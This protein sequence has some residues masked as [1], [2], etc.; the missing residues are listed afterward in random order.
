MMRKAFLVLIIV[1]NA[2]SAMAQQPSAQNQADRLHRIDVEL[3][4]L[5]PVI[6]GFPPNIE[7]EDQQSK[8]EE[9]YRQLVAQINTALVES[10]NDL[11]LLYRRGKLYS[12]GHNIDEPNAWKNAERDL[13]ELIKRKPYD[14][15]AFLEL[16]HLYVNT[17]PDFAPKAEALFLQAQKVHGQEP[18]GEAHR[19]L[20]F[21][22]YYQGKMQKALGEADLVL[23]LT[24]KDKTVAT[25]R[26]IIKTK[27]Q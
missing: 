2:I 21:A 6:G 9:Q 25:I 12:M 11:E 8:V 22:Y 23:K 24:P 26:D 19:G 13:S 18:L 7:N 15:R 20:I 17:H 4:K 10:P 1:A 5:E 27:I 16:G 3:S 14:E